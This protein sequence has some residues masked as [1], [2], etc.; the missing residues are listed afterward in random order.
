MEITNLTN[1]IYQVKC[2]Q[3]I[4]SVFLISI[5]QLQKQGTSLNVKVFLLLM[6]CCEQKYV[7][8][9]K[10]QLYNPELDTSVQRLWNA[11]SISYQ[12]FE[13][14]VLKMIEKWTEKAERQLITESQGLEG[15]SR[16]DQILPPCQNSLHTAGCTDRCPDGS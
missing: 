1:L 7:A 6:K 8:P 5:S 12:C 14:T 3:E 2:S 16:H 11:Q 9:E 13:S 15:T 4:F 10:E